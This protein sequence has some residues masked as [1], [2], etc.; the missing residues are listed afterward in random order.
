MSVENPHK[1]DATYRTVE[2]SAPEAKRPGFRLI[3]AAVSDD[4]LGDRARAIPIG[5]GEFLLGRGERDSVVRLGREGEIRV[6]DAK[7]SASHASV[8]ATPEGLVLRD[9][10]S[11][12]GT[13]VNGARAS[14]AL[15]R[16]GDVAELGRSFFTCAR[17]PDEPDEPGPEEVRG[18]LRTLDP[19]L[20]SQ[21][22][23]AR[24]VSSSRV[25][26]LLLGESGTGKELLARELHV[27][28]GRPG[29]LVAVHCGAIPEGLI[30]GQLFGYKRGA[31]T[32]ALQ[33][34]EGLISA[35]DGG[36]LFLDEIGE[37]PL[38]AQVRLLRV[39]QEREVV[40][41][42]ETRP[43][44]VDLRLVAA[45]NRDLRAMA[46][47]GSFRGDLYARLEGVTLQL[48]PLRERRGDIGIL[49]AHFLRRFAG[50]A[51][52]RC[53]PTPSALRA[54]FLYE[55]PF[56][57]RELEK[58]VEAAVALCG[59]SRPIEPRDLPAAL[60]QSAEASAEPGALPE[61][62]PAGPEEDALRQQLI[63]A[64]ARHQGNVSA[65]AREWGKARM[66]IQRWMRRFQL[67]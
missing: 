31:F 2:E 65:V 67:R 41:L 44:K 51:A 35:A 56:N 26:V 18:D 39:L 27:A 58:V 33:S 52:A 50:P 9:L 59:A 28:S 38:Q 14:S 5:E 42:G 3:L 64:L 47:A 6:R 55:W 11:T 54:L 37:M 25:S 23:K 61:P 15:L 29:R 20:L 4:L 49:V 66:Q 19:W 34:A 17:T 1:T 7:M 8:R 30:E 22:A 13:W 21:L 36:T 10:G 43:R 62:E 12:N 46:L 63:E 48:R 24:R 57:I 40:P 16:P 32:G 53:S 45:T 60:L